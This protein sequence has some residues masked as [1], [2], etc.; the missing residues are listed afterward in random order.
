MRTR[1][2]AIP[3]ALTALLSFTIASAE[4]PPTHTD[5][6]SSLPASLDRFYPPQ[7]TRP[8]FLIAMRELNASLVGIAVELG[9]GD[10]QNAT[11]MLGDFVA[12]YSDISQMI[13]EWSDRYPAE[14]LAALR[15]A[16]EAGD[17]AAAMASIGQLGATCHDCHVATMVPAHQRYHWPDFAEVMVEDP[18]SE[19]TLAFP[20]FMQLLNASMV[21]MGVN[22]RQG[23]VEDAR[24][25]L[26]A[27]RSRMQGLRE[28]CDSCHDS[29]RRYFV[30]EDIELLLSTISAEMDRQP[31][32]SEAI[33]HLARRVGEEACSRCHLVH[34]PAAYSPAR[35]R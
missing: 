5:G 11:T 6:P 7:S 34:L 9:E 22:L 29:E 3:I 24:V 35:N 28:S 18:I 23:D 31:L 14:P 17:M 33:E 27:F 13:P 1:V 10:A 8:A 26:E 32:D 16:V 2:L 4:Q 21:G 19:T 20:P 12:R 25:H 30:D 15:A